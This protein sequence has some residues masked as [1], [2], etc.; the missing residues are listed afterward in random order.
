MKYITKYISLAG[1]QTRSATK[2][3]KENCG[4]KM[5][6]ITHIYLEKLIDCG[7]AEQFSAL[8]QSVYPTGELRPG[9]GV[10]PLVLT[11]RQFMKHIL[12]AN[13]V[14]SAEKC[15][16]RS[17]YGEMTNI[18]NCYSENLIDNGFVHIS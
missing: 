14:P 15:R 17:S 4:E 13:Y 16:V 12:V 9:Y 7:S 11:I 2:N 3:T 18:T 5:N 8:R 6:T 1:I 10:H